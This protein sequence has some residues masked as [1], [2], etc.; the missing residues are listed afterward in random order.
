MNNL[1]I[2]EYILGNAK[3]I[4]HLIYSRAVQLHESKTMI[5]DDQFRR[6]F[7]NNLH[8]NFPNIKDFPELKKHYEDL[9]EEICKDKTQIHPIIYNQELEVLKK[10]QKI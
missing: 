6:D 10:L 4:C 9:I 3:R 5:Y 8:K 2:S 1:E 7:L